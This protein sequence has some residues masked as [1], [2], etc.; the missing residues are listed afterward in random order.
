MDDNHNLSS[1]TSIKRFLAHY[2]RPRK[3]FAFGYVIISMLWAFELMMNP[4]LIKLII[5]KVINSGPNN[6]VMLQ[7]VFPFVLCF[8]LLSI[9]LNLNFRFYDYL[10]MHLYPKLKVDI[11][12]DMFT[13]LLEYQWQYFQDN[14]TGTITKKIFDMAAHIEN[15]IRIP[16]EW[17]IPRFLAVIVSAIM[18]A[19]V[20]RPIFGIILVLWAALYLWLSVYAAKQSAKLAKGFSKSLLKTDG[21]VVDAISNVFNTKI[22]SSQQQEVITLSGHLSALQKS[23]TN[24]QRQNMLVHFFQALAVTAFIAAM[25]SGLIYERYLGKITVG[26][27]VLVITLSLSF[28][29]AI[30]N[31]GQ[32]I[33]S[34][35]KSVGICQ[36]ALTLLMSGKQNNNVTTSAR[37][38]NVT[39]ALEFRNISFGYASDNMLYNHFSLD[40][41]PGS[42]VAIIGQS[43]AGKTTL[44]NLILRLFDLATGEIFLDNSPLSQF[45]QSEL[46]QQIAYIPQSPQL[47][48]RSIIDN[49]LIANPVST[50]EQVIT[51][52]KAAQCHDFIMNLPE[53]YKTVVGTQGTKLSG[54][55][56]QR[57]AIA[58]A[59]L[60]D[61]SVLLLDEATSNLDVKTEHA[62]KK[63]LFSALN[64]KTIIFIAH[65]LISLKQAD[66]VIILDNGKVIEDG[67]L[68]AMRN[69]PSSKLNKIWQ[70]QQ[71]ERHNETASIS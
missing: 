27:F 18:L 65:S 22:F 53:K 58:R 31:M 5:D 68:E 15:I 26:D 66:R 69:N 11:I 71:L 36:Q 61:A 55:Q 16:N 32:Q 23:D 35:S 20:V 49:L 70:I 1:A 63:H 17:F 7:G 52:C 24:L 47:Y 39:G 64:H 54:G 50:K 41:S 3:R 6:H 62:I 25:F 67:T 30:Y 46:S 48:D 10:N 42:K 9:G 37:L 4:Y 21:H 12:K 28:I 2:L 56:K 59:L 34:L 13:N 60:L 45:D 14:A 33:I 38:K 8:L 43:G 29:G 57:I 40:I 51:A 19:I 44:F